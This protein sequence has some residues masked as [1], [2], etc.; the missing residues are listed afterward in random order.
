MAQ[1]MMYKSPGPY[2]L[3]G[4]VLNNLAVD[5]SQVEAAKAEGWFLT[6][7]EAKKAQED[8]QANVLQP[9]AQVEDE[10]ADLVE[11]PKH[12]KKDRK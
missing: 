1:V 8:V 6:A 4:G 3:Y 9:K 10:R 7:D 11:E 2:A 5:E 12:G